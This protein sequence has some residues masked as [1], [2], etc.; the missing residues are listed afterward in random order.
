MKK[1][2]TSLT[3]TILSL[4]FNVLFAQSGN[5]QHVLHS[6]KPVEK[7]AVIMNANRISGSSGILSLNHPYTPGKEI[8]ST[9]D[10]TNST[11]N[12]NDSILYTYNGAGSSTLELVYDHTGTQSY[13]TTKTYDVSNNLTLQLLQIWDTI[14]WVNSN[15]TINSYNAGNQRTENM[16]Q[17]WDIG[18]N[19]WISDDRTTSFYNLSGQLT[20]D[21]YQYWDAGLLTW[22]NFSKNDYTYNVDSQLTEEIGQRWNTTSLGWDNT[23]KTDFRYAI[24][25]EVDSITG[26]DSSGTGWALNYQNINIVWYQWTGSIFHGDNKIAS[27]LQQSWNG[28]SWQNLQRGAIAYDVYANDTDNVTESWN[29]SSWATQY[30]THQIFTYDGDHNI[31]QDIEQHWDNVPQSLVSAWK[32]DY[33]NYA[34]ITY[35]HTL[36]QDDFGVEVFPNPFHTETTVLLSEIM[37]SPAVL[38]LCNLMG[39]EVK[40]I[41]FSG[42]RVKI[43]R[44]NLANGIYFYT[45]VRENKTEVRG[46]ISAN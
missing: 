8:A 33:S 27:Y 44:N 6:F 25:G 17:H 20:E 9:W 24:G 13:R 5:R 23:G 28:S 4:T 1:L 31:A 19:A 12:Y 38:F 29:G 22:V 40:R 11:W 43:E 16:N 34:G 18:S 37:Q 45:I 30:A 3:V 14:A 21:Q 36:K 35:I 10:T 41:Q 46:K 39:Q 42:D 2:F 7:N 15:Q 26:Y 32:Y